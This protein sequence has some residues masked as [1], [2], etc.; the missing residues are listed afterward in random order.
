MIFVEDLLARLVKI[1]GSGDFH[2]TA[3]PED[4][5]GLVAA[6]SAVFSEQKLVE[7]YGPSAH[8]NLDEALES[9]VAY[10]RQQLHEGEL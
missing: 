7:A 6:S 1:V 5:R 4:F 10:F 2:V 9:T 3:I 8:T